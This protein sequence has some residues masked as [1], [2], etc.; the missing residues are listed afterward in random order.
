MINKHPLYTPDMLS[1]EDRARLDKL[2]EKFEYEADRF[3]GYPCTR[4]FDFSPLFP[5]MF[6]PLNNVG[7]PFEDTTFR[8]NTHDIECEVLEY[9]R[10]Y[11]EAPKNG[12]W[13]YMTNGGTEGNMYGIYLARELHPNGVVY[14]S[15]DTHYSV[16]KILRLLHARNIMI[17]SLPNGEIDYEDLKETL[18]IHRDVPPIIFA[19]IGTTMKGAVDNLDKIKAVLNDL[20]IRDYYIHADAALSGMILPFVK[21]PQPWNFRSGVDS[22]SISGHKMIGSPIPCGVVIAKKANVE[23]IARSVEYIGTLDTTLTGSRN[24]ITPLFL[25]Y[26]IRAQGW[27]GFRKIILRCFKT[28]DYA[29]TKFKQ[30]GIDAW[31]NNNSITVVFPRPGPQI[32]KKWQLAVHGNHAHIITMPHVEERHINAILQDLIDDMKKGNVA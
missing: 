18:R 10:E 31:R 8:L 24:A 13:G 12:F 30:A 5:F 21:D 20:A 16:A 19:N 22:V 29:I 32:M 7:D 27:E 11:T 25:W 3:L 26:A 1:A 17:R 15:E 23:R 28:A 4:D 6:Y 14:Y 2:L 9:F